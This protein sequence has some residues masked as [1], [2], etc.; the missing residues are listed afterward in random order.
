MPTANHY[1]LSQFSAFARD[2]FDDNFI[3]FIFPLPTGK[4]KKS[5][6]RNKKNFQSICLKADEAWARLAFWFVMLLL[7]CFNK[8]SNP[9]FRERLFALLHSHAILFTAGCQRHNI[10]WSRMKWWKKK[11]LINSNF[12]F[13]A[14]FLCELHVHAPPLSEPFLSSVPTESTKIEP[15]KF[16]P[17]RSGI[18]WL[19]RS[20]MEKC[21][22][23]DSLQPFYILPSLIST[24]N[25]SALRNTLISWNSFSFFMSG[26][27]TLSSTLQ[28]S[29]IHAVVLI[30]SKGKWIKIWQKDLRTLAEPSMDGIKMI[31]RG[32]NNKY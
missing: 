8:V 11:K 5:F 14:L 19:C 26:G 2:A 18:P 31:R 29:S 10:E 23:S 4:T 21:V 9:L 12:T 28:A 24:H 6:L 16:L 7:W 27:L 25:I 30:W 1:S 22:L 17:A 3:E 15:K 13:N 32:K 20:L